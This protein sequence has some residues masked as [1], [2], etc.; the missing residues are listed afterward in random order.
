MGALLLSDDELKSA[1]EDAKRRWQAS[2]SRGHA[3]QMQA[4]QTQGQAEDPHAL[5]AA[6]HRLSCVAAKRWG[7]LR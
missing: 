5:Q 2:L 7:L 4:Q 1:L 6:Y 3:Q